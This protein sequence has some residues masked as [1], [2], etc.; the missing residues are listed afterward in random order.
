IHSDS[1]S[2]TLSGAEWKEAKRLLECTK[3]DTI[4]IVWGSPE[5]VDTAVKEIAIRAREVTVGIPSETR[6]ALRDGTTGF[7]RI[8][9]G[10]QRMYP[11]TDLPPIR[12]DEER[13]ERLRARMPVQYWDRLREFNKAGVPADAVDGLAISPLAPLFDVAVNEMGFSAMEAAV[14][15][16]RHP[17][18]LLREGFTYEELDLDQIRSIMQ[19]VRDGRITRDGVLQYLRLVAL[20]A[21]HEEA[22]PPRLERR[23]LS[24]FIEKAKQQ[25]RYSTLHDE[26]NI[27]NL[28]LDKVMD[29]VRGRIPGADV[30][31]EVTAHFAKEVQA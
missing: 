9:P 29:E 14:A 26:K 25:V 13:I 1:M 4:V 2:E 28:T 6:Q 23:E 11:D 30:A 15:L 22:I 20:G 10:P 3:D 7:E 31:E 21:F 24:S 19:A 12:V 8:L 18:R 16:W 17:R 5:D 27:P